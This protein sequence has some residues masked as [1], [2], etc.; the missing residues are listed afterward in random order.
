MQVDADMME[1]DTEFPQKLKIEWPYDPEIPLLGIYP[2]KIKTIIQ[3]YTC[4]PVFIATL[5][6]ITKTWKQP[7]CPSTDEWFKKM[8]HTYTMEYYS[9]IK[10]NKILPFAATWMGL[11]NIMLSEISQTEKDKYYIISLIYGV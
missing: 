9:I 10:T 5:F 3:K 6:I 7:K 11:E 8:R 1:N 2:E 4:T